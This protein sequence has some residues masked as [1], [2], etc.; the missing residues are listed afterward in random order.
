M[1]Q[2]YIYSS[3]RVT[4]LPALKQTSAGESKRPAYRTRENYPAVWH[5]L[6]SAPTPDALLKDVFP[7]LRAA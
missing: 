1:Q 7:R 2:K 5:E 6:A 4:W 3:Q